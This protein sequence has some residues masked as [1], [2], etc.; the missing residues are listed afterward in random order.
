MIFCKERRSKLKEE[1]PELP[2]GKLGAKLGEIWRQMPQEQ[3]KPYEDRASMDRERYRKQMQDYQFSSP[4]RVF[5]LF[6][7]CG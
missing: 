4:V 3:K 1:H 7:C 5:C 2:F 6:C